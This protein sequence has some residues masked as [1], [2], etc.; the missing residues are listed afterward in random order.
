M[1]RLFM[2]ELELPVVIDTDFMKMIPSHRAYISQL[3]NEGKIQS[4]SINTER[5][6]GW[7]IF[8]CKD[9]EAVFEIVEQFPIYKYISIQVHDLMIHD[10]EAFRFPKMHM[11]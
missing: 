4:Y 5:T 3:I 10:S 1:K 11:N 9:A 7:I 8:N 6:L 2:V